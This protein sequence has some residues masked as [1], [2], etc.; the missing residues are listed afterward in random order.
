MPVGKI[1]LN[2][3]AKGLV[4]KNKFDC[5][6]NLK[7]TV[8]Y[9][10]FS[11]SFEKNTV[12]ISYISAPE[13][14]VTKNI[15]INDAEHSIGGNNLSEQTEFLKLT[16]LFSTDY[17]NFLLTDVFKTVDG[18]YVPL[19]LRHD[20]SHETLGVSHLEVLNAN[21]TPVDPDLWSFHDEEST[22]G[23]SSKYIYTNLECFLNKK[24]KTYKTY[25]IRYKSLETQ[26]SK[27]VLLDTKPFYERASFATTRTRRDYILT[28]EPGSYQIEV[29]FD[30]LNYSPTPYASGQRYSLKIQEKSV[31]KI[32]PP[33]AS[34]PGERWYL[35]VSPG[36]LQTAGDRY[37]VPELYSQQYRPVYP[38]R[39][40]SEKEAVL[41]E[42][43]LIKTDIFPIAN[44]GIEGYFVEVIVKDKA[45][46]VVRAF[47]NNPDADNFVTKN[48]FIADIFFETDKIESVSSNS[49]FI[50]LKEK[51]SSEYRVFLN[52]RYIEKYYTYQTLSVN[53]SISP[54]ILGK[55]IV[56]Y[57][58]PNASTQAIHHLIVQDDGVIVGASETPRLESVFGEA[59]GGTETSLVDT[60][61][62]TEDYYSNYELEISSGDNSGRKVRIAGYDAGNKTLVL[63]HSLP[64][65]IAKGTL[66]Q[67]NKKVTSYTSIDTV[68]GTSEDYIGWEE[69][70]QNNRDKKLADVFVIQT[71]SIDD[72]TSFDARIEGG[73]LKEKVVNSAMKLQ[74]ESRWY[75]DVGNFDGDPYPGMSSVLVE[76]PR[77]IL[78]E[79]DGPFSREQALSVVQKHM[80]E[81]SYP[82]IKYYDS[83][84]EITK[85]IPGNGQIYLSWRIISASKYNIYVGNSGDN[86]GLMKSE[87]GTRGETIL[88]GL[89]NNKEYF[90]QVEPVVGGIERLRSRTMAVMPYDF[91]EA[92]PPIKYDKEK[93]SGGTYD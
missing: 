28:E 42:P 26:E 54:E 21:G 56:M 36:D 4:V 84:T 10:R 2:Y 31:I 90:I 24:E 92:L 63:A 14:D 68:L 58:K 30:S 37:W 53:P 27:T 51:I 67:I 49:G 69:E 25:Y 88:D 13:L 59:S 60:T 19:Y 9:L 52:Y 87:P 50:K 72:I 76:L 20:L 78:K 6:I 77:H 12:G 5:R 66:Y 18:E 1:T 43:D 17:A 83:S 47:S 74:D 11:T 71:V 48:G 46:A 22:Y 44:L 57:C 16:D 93:Y 45:G 23:V 64:A 33:A 82:V 79:L 3:G 55:R 35:R 80:A 65:P 15:L 32:D 39:T 34:T 38:F 75:W 85:V 91:A 61:L 29:V 86:L 41:I 7:D 70:A 81:G 8:E 40:A 73:G 62:D 89:E